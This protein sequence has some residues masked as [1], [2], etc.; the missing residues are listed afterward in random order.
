MFT[1]ILRKS[2]SAITADHLVLT[3]IVPHGIIL[4]MKHQ[5]ARQRY[6]L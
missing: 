3:V 6:S 4:F 1:Q 5:K 2:D